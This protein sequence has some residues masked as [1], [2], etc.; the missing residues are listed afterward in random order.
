LPDK[1]IQSAGLQAMVGH[2]ADATA[3]D[4]AS[5]A[6]LDLSAH[7]ARQ[8]SNELVQWADL[9][10]MMSENQ[11]RMLSQSSP[12]ALGKAMLLGHWLPA[13]INNTSNKDIPDPYKKSREVFEHVHRL[14]DQSVRLWAGKI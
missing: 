9:I 13:G 11:R 1:Q 3:A 10:L 4:I 14:M 6:G 12:E 7:K 5:A 8:I 2:G